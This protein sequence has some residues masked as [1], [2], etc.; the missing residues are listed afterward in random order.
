MRVILLIVAV[1]VVLYAYAWQVSNDT[2]SSINRE[3]SVYSVGGVSDAMEANP[4]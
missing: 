4:C 1:V 3:Q 2:R